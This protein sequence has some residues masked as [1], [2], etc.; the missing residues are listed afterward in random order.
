ME[1][2]NHHPNGWNWDLVTLATVQCEENNQPF[3]MV[4]FHF[5]PIVL[6]CACLG[7]G[8]GPPGPGS[9]LHQGVQ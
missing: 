4:S 1:P 2:R 6:W 3:K 5:E 8:G 7:H 9:L